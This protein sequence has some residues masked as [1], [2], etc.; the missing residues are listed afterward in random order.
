MNALSQDPVAAL[1]PL[2]RADE[3]AAFLHDPV[4]CMSSL[5][6]NHGRMVA[7]RKEEA[8]VVFAFGADA[9]YQILTNPEVFH[10]VSCFPGPRNSAQRRFRSGLFSM[11][12]AEHQKHRRLLTP[13]FRKEQAAN[14][15]QP[16]LRLLEERLASWQ[17]GQTID[18]AREMKE[19]TLRF[20]TFFLFGLEELGAAHEIEQLFEEWLNLNHA[21][22]FSMWLPCELPDGIYARLL[23]V[24]GRL[25]EQLQALLQQKRAT[26]GQGHDIL[27]ILMRARSEGAITETEVIGQTITLFN[28]AYHTTTSALTW[29]LFLLYQHPEVARALLTEVEEHLG[30]GPF[31]AAQL[32]KITLLDR[33]IKEGLRLLPPV[34][35]MPRVTACRCELGGYTLPAQ[36]FVLP[37]PYM[38][39]HLAEEFPDPER[40]W[41]DRWLSPP[42][43]YAYVP[44]GGGAR[45]CLGAPIALMMVRTALASILRSFR[46]SIVPGA[47]IERTGT[48][49]L[50]A[51]FGVP[52]VV[53]RQDR[54]FGASHVVGNIHEM[55]QLPGALPEKIA[56]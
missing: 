33:V 38:S 20:T 41:P 30:D 36:T 18:L 11:N 19:L 10:I 28:A 37:S 56:A 17:D 55:V 48:L 42:S 6:R 32:D 5:Y 15:Y 3:A 54:R 35:Y 47:L 27:S 16:F 22:S 12:G 34:V 24:A 46:L 14:F 2:G 23:D 49:T 13:P 52:A 53:H 39:H 40:Y 4:G 1:P 26:Q 8:A 21:V 9:N 51:R 43:P 25:E 45:L 50:E 31:S 44:F 29:N 7:F